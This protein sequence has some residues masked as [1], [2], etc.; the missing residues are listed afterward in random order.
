M[1]TPRKATLNQT[2][3]S[4]LVFSAV[5]LL[6]LLWPAQQINADEIA[7]WNFNDSDLVVDHGVGTLTTNFN[8]VNVLFTSGGTTTNA[9]QGDVAGQ[10]MTLQGGTSN[11]NNGRT[12][13][14]NVSTFGFNN[15]VISFATLRTSTGFNSNQFQYSLDGVAFID[16][17]VPYT[18]PLAFG[19]VTFDLSGISGVSDNPNA[20][21]RIVFNGATSAAGN[22]RIDNLVVEGPT[23]ATPIP[24]P[25]SMLLLSLGLTGTLATRFKMSRRKAEHRGD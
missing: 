22:N 15:I 21:F 8:L 3:H 6:L 25:A 13:N 2:L 7:I 17:G 18:P 16:F 23:I 5:L 12:L 20:A 1:P 19:L 14:L 11:A 24:E 10:S 4:R 9:R